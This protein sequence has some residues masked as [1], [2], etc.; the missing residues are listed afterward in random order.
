MTKTVLYLLGVMLVIAV[1]LTL[2]G[3]AST[4]GLDVQPEAQIVKVP[5][6]T[7]C[8]DSIPQPDDPFLTDAQLLDGNDYQVV[9]NL[10]ADRDARRKYEATLT[11]V[12]QACTK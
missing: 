12:M 1:I 8:I 6:I 2:V 3:C 5:V 9:N 10:R 7:P 4:P 11:S